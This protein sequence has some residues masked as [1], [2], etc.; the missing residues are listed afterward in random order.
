M[1]NNRIGRFR[2]RVTLLAPSEAEVL[3]DVGQPIESP[4]TVGTFWAEVTPQGGGEQLAAD[5]VKHT[6]THQVTMR[7]LGS[8]PIT[9]KHKLLFKGRTLNILNVNNTEE[10]DR[11]LVLSCRE[12]T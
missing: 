3:D 10:R 4:T 6:A 8:I 1:R 2:Q 12:V 9:E 5:S 11:Q 7:Y